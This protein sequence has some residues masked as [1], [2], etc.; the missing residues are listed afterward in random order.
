MDESTVLQ[1]I[2]T[3]LRR[4]IDP[5]FARYLTVERLDVPLVTKAQITANQNDYAIGN[6]SAF[7]VSSD[8]SRNVT[9][10]TGG[11]GGKLLI[12]INVGA[13]SIVL[14]NQNTGSAAA[15]RIITGTGADYTLAT[16]KTVMLIYDATTTRWNLFGQ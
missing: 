15:N 13:Q 10:I 12:I 1:L 3:A 9:G 14:Q 7:R 5:M 16:L 11:F 6:G 8:A 2:C 4:F